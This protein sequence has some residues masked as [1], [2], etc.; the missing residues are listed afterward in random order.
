MSVKKLRSIT[1]TFQ[2]VLNQELSKVMGS[3]DEGNT[4]QAYT[5]LQTL[6]DALNPEHTI[7]L[8]KE[9]ARIDKKINVALGLKGVDLYQTRKIQKGTAE[10]VT[11]QETRTLFRKVMAILHKGGYFEVYQRYE[12]GQELGTTA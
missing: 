6:I 10:T 4:F 1:P 3:I 2:A 5:T 7:E 11:K 12:R 9:I 8:R